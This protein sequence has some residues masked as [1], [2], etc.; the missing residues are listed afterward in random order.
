[1]QKLNQCHVRYPLPVVTDKLCDLCQT[2]LQE[3]NGNVSESPAAAP[4]GLRTQHEEGCCWLCPQLWQTSTTPTETQWGSGKSIVKLAQDDYSRNYVY[5]SLAIFYIFSLFSKYYQS[6]LYN[7]V[8][9]KMNLLITTERIRSH[10]TWI[11]WTFQE[12]HQEESSPAELLHAGH[13]R[14]VV[15]GI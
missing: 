11:L 12:L 4:E 14:D 7:H 15:P 13:P 10:G 3:P 9:H 2:F 1:M 5:I 6:Y 8:V